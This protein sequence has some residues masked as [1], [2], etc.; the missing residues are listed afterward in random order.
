MGTVDSDVK[1]LA[2]NVSS[3]QKDMAQVGVLVDRLDVTIEK[4]TEVSSTVSQLL[5]VQ[6]SRLEFHEKVQ[7]KLQDLVEKRRQETDEN[8]KSVYNRIEKVEKDLQADMENTEDRIIKKIEEMQKS[9]TEQHEKINNGIT[10]RIDRLEKWMWT[11]IGGG[12][13]IVW[14]LNNVDIMKIF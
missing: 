13:V 9:G 5:A 3:L 8:I 6:G 14:I 7:E 1:K 4:L 10:E 2:E 11:A 12:A